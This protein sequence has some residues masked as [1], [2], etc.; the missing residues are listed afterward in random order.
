MTE[1]PDGKNG[2]KREPQEA[3]ADGVQ[4][5][6]DF[7]AT[8]YPSHAGILKSVAAGLPISPNERMAALSDTLGEKRAKSGPLYDNLRQAGVRDYTPPKPHEVTDDPG[9]KRKN[10]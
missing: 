6:T 9:V 3:H 1:T 7:R 5:G 8:L 2:L 10:R 4:E